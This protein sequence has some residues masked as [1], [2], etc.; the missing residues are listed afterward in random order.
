MSRGRGGVGAACKLTTGGVRYA[1]IWT[2]VV[3][4]ECDAGSGD[5]LWTVHT[6]VRPAPRYGEDENNSVCAV[7]V[8]TYYY[9]PARVFGATCGGDSLFMDLL[10]DFDASG[11]SHVDNN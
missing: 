4:T 2:E 6:Y 9:Q 8:C 5:G 3:R 7:W 10:W 1:A 11:L